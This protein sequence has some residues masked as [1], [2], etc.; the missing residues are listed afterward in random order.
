[1]ASGR[2][3]ERVVEQHVLNLDKRWMMLD[4][5]GKAGKS[6]QRRNDAAEA[7]AVHEQITSLH[8]L[9]ARSVGSRHW[10]TRRL[11]EMLSG[12]EASSTPGSGY[13]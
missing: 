9:V 7:L 3:W 5:A 13:R 6:A 4:E 12:R 1:V 2:A 10:T 8:G 11:V